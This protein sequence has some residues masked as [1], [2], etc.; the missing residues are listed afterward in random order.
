MTA[1]A[2]PPQ[3]EPMKF[4]YIGAFGL[5]GVFAR[6]LLGQTVDNLGFSSMP[7]GTLLVNL[8]GAFAVG[9]VYAW[10][11]DRGA[12]PEDLKVGLMVGL[13]GGFTTFSAYCLQT[14]QLFEESRFLVASLYMALS[15]GL[16]FLFVVAG[17]AFARRFS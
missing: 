17:I 6:Y 12:L 14:V 3:Y 2:A 16:G 5:V 9:A 10:G 1:A 11:I 7:L 4:A 13:L 8:L 15:N